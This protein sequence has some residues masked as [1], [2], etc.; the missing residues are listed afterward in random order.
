[1]R[2]KEVNF[3]IKTDWVVEERGTTLC[4]PGLGAVCSIGYPYAVIWDCVTRGHGE[5]KTLRMFA[6]VARMDKASAAPL[7][8]RCLEEWEN[9]GFISRESGDA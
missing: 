9:A 7:L 6:A 3:R 2:H 4:R 5:E 8:R 1:M